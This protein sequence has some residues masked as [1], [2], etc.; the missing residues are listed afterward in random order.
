MDCAMVYSLSF[1]FS[2]NPFGGNV[3][4]GGGS[5]VVDVCGVELLS[6]LRVCAVLCRAAQCRALHRFS[7]LSVRSL[8]VW[9]FALRSSPILGTV[10]IRKTLKY[11]NF[12]G[13]RDIRHVVQFRSVC[14][15]VCGSRKNLF[16]KRVPAR[17]PPSRS[18]SAPFQLLLVWSP[19]IVSVA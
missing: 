14:L 1:S 17:L 12:T 19:K 7:L 10:Q 6:S 18:Q 5:G 16:L 9:R 8:F 3:C 13:V 4:D 15:S 11:R 2:I